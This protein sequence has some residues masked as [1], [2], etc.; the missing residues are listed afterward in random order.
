M[1]AQRQAQAA[2]ESATILL[3]E[4]MDAMASQGA[5]MLM[6]IRAKAGMSGESVYSLASISPP[7]KGS[8]VG[9]PGKPSRFEFS[10]DDLGALRMTWKC[11]N[12][13][14]SAG[15][16]Y[17]VYREVDGSGEMAFIGTTG[18]KQF[19]D[20]TVPQGAKQIVY[21]VRAMRSTKVGQSATFNVSF[22]VDR[23]VRKMIAAQKMAA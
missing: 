7:A 2:A 4:A 9:E 6:Q 5:S 13:R 15:T 12:P 3:K 14:G 18:K 8:P 23:A 20:A 11:K 10:I 1:A 19:M 21:K 17:Q 16:M 22:G